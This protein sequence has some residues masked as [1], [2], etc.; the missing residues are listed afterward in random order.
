VSREPSRVN[1]EATSA[2][3]NLRK[4]AAVIAVAASLGS[5][6]AGLSSGIAAA[7]KWTC[8]VELRSAA[9]TVGAAAPRSI[10]GAPRCFRSTTLN[11]SSGGSGSTGSGYRWRR[12]SL[13][14][15][16]RGLSAS[17]NRT[18]HPG[19]MRIGLVEHVLQMGAKGLIWHRHLIRHPFQAGFTGQTR[20]DFRLRRLHFPVRV[21][22]DHQRR[23]LTD[24]VV[25]VG[26]CRGTTFTMYGRFK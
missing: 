6:V 13:A 8:A 1:L 9:T 14:L 12:K 19:A 10:T 23:R 2:T 11:S 20:R 17:S 25:S 22:R 4:T 7:G 16:P 21:H 18:A 15:S 24:H 26:K 5:R 3:T